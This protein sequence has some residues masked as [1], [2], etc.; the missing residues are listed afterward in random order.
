MPP[1]LILS[2]DQTLML[3]VAALGPP[4]PRDLRRNGP[5]PSVNWFNA[6]TFGSSALSDCQV[7]RLPSK[8]RDPERP[9]ADTRRVVSQRG[10][11]RPPSLARGPA[12]STASKRVCACTH[13]LVFKE[14]TD[15]RRFRDAAR[16]ALPQGA[17]DVTSAR[18]SCQPFSF[19]PPDS[20]S[21]APNPVSF[22]GTFQ[23]Y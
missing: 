8:S 17:F 21:G 2:Q 13:Y 12:N 11:V 19:G 5:W 7:L 14:P 3:N 1:A 16:C 18:R 15:L 22:W 23:S 4:R 9:Q 20:L 10:L 6:R